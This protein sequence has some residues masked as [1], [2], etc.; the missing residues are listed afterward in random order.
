MKFFRF[1]ILVLISGLVGVQ[2]I[3]ASLN[4]NTVVL[5]TDFTKT[6]KVPE[7][8]N[9][10]VDNS[11]GSVNV[12]NIGEAEVKLKASSGSIKA[13]SINSSLVI[14]ASSGSLSASALSVLKLYHFRS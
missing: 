3:P 6:F 10:N 5:S 11:S 1:L 2:F 4:Q 12:A 8:T 9:L 7:N 14:G 13:Q